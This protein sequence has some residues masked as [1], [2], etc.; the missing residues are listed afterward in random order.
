MSKN[1]DYLIRV[2]LLRCASSFVTEAYSYVRLSPPDEGVFYL[3]R[4]A[5]SDWKPTDHDRIMVR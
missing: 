2:H 1:V 4:F 5:S 3:H